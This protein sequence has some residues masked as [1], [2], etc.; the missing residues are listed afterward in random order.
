MNS[1]FQFLQNSFANIITNIL[2]FVPDILIAFALI[3]LGWI[4]GDS[5]GKV[6]SSAAKAMNADNFFKQVGLENILSR[7]GIRLNVGGF[8]GWLV[9]WTIFIVFLLAGFEIGGIPETG[10]FINDVFT[11][12]FPKIFT[13]V[14]VIFLAVS[15]AQIMRKTV[16]L[17]ISSLGLEHAHFP[18]VIA[19]YSFAIA[20]FLFVF[21]RIGI[22]PEFL[23]IAFIGL[24]AGFSLAFGLAFGFGGRVIAEKLCEKLYKDIM[25]E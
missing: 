23:K 20:A 21:S 6:I 1:S 18:S 17:G 3:G 7:I 11:S 15:G 8:L 2:S 12:Y 10:I 4:I 19:G 14:I 9:Q 22:D 5:F 16:Y 24:V 13:A 25:R